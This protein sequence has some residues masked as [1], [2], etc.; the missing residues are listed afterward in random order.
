M[1][2]DMC[3][4]VIVGFCLSGREYSFLIRQYRGHADVLMCCEPGYIWMISHLQV[5]CMPEDRY[6]L[7]SFMLSNRMLDGTHPFVSVRYKK[8]TFPGALLIL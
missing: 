2:M 3:D 5:H 7:F 6:D 4:C 8:N 1:F